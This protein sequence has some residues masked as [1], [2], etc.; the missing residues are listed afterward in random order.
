MKIHNRV[1]TA[2]IATLTAIALAGC[3]GGSGNT[4]PNSQ[5][6]GGEP[7]GTLTGLFFSTFKDTYEQIAADFEKKYP[8]VDVQFD[9][10]GG[11]IGALTMTQL[12]GG[13]APDILTSFPGGTKT[14]A[15][16]TVVSLAA[17]GRIAP[18]DAPW[19]KDVPEAWQPSANYEDKTFAYP[20]ALQP[21]SGIYNKTKL[22]ELGLKIPT[23]LDEVYQLCTAAKDKGIYAYSLGLGDPAGPQMLTYSQLGTLEPDPAQF[24]AD[25]AAGKKT[26]ADSKWVDQFEIYKKMGDLG[27]FGEGALGRS[28]DQAGQEVAKGSALGTVDVG[29]A[30]APIKTAAPGTSFEVAPV[31]ATNNAADT[32]VVA[33]PG[34]VNTINAKAK[35]PTAAQA[36]LAFMGEA[37]PSATYAKGFSSVPVLPNDA[38]TAPA[39]LATFAD[40]VERGAYAP[41]GAVQAEVQAQ[42]NQTIQSLI[43]GDTTPRQVAEKLDSVY[44]K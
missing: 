22:D 26:Y 1:T 21:L 3:A 29:A 32:K 20:G 39:E 28:R 16:D 17:S 19:T 43:L 9:Y 4:A 25:L 10:Q 30:L 14:D 34:F 35:N 27:C 6:S 23:T 15:G 38:Y 31:P 24:D 8:N 18:L 40:L 42:L 12:Q 11:D 44:K 36:F 33:L 7:S 41:L 2:A 5:A 13:T 37:D